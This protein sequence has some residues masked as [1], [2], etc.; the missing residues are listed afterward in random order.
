MPLSIDKPL[1]TTPRQVTGLSTLESPVSILDKATRI[2]R[3]GRADLFNATPSQKSGCRMRYN[4]STKAPR[5]A[6]DLR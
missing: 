4:V 3:I 6:N 1:M 5:R 2:K